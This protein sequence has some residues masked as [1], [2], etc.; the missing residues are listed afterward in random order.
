MPI[1]RNSFRNRAVFWNDL[2]VL[3]SVKF[4]DVKKLQFSAEFFN[5]CNIDNVVFSGANG[6]LFGGVY[7]PGLQ[8]NG[9]TAVIDPRFLR[10]KLA[11]GSYD[12]N[13][14]QTGTP[15]QVQFGLRFFF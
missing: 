3:K 13:N 5:L 9:Q 7:G 4:G 1:E 12:R 14:A 8:S 6:G 2:R 10:L 11:D 15:L